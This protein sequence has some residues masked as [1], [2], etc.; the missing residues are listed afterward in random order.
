MRSCLSPR[1]CAAA[2]FAALVPLTFGVRP[3]AAQTPSDTKPPSILTVRGG[4][5][6]PSN[7]RV[8]NTTGTTWYGG[9]LD[10]HFQQKPGISRTVLSVDYIQRSSGGNQ[11]RIIPVTVGQFTISGSPEAKY[12]PYYGVGAGAYFVHQTIPNDVGIVETNNV[13]AFG[14]YVAAGIE[15]KDNL[16]LEA[17]YHI[18][19][20]VGSATSSGLQVMAGFRL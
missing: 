10:Y 5:Y 6:F 12:H 15:F 4:A 2:V 8:K 19:N 7:T 11:I 20:K 17:R 3:A 14:G 9:G 18:L 1:F 13:T 16:L